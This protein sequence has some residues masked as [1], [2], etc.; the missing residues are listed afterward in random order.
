MKSNTLSIADQNVQLFKFQSQHFHKFF[1]A[2]SGLPERKGIKALDR[3]ARMLG[4]QDFN[5][6]HN[7]LSRQTKLIKSIPH[8][9]R[10]AIMGECG[11]YTDNLEL[12]SQVSTFFQFYFY[13]PVDAPE[14]R[15]LYIQSLRKM[16]SFTQFPVKRNS[17]LWDSGDYLAVALARHL[18]A[19]ERNEKI[20]CGVFIV[21]FGLYENDWISGFGFQDVI[22]MLH[23]DKLMESLEH[24]GALSYPGSSSAESIHAK[25][26][27][28]WSRADLEDARE[29]YFD[30]FTVFSREKLTMHQNPIDTIF[31]RAVGFIGETN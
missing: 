9:S 30:A 12:L 14:R 16:T 17:P 5:H 3:Y 31:D 15:D 13:V 29:F 7:Y 1:A 19:S 4:L 11:D 10:E 25:I 24:Y 6:A 18:K 28:H 8:P 20:L 27:R 21:L 2:V 23:P 26:K 22:D